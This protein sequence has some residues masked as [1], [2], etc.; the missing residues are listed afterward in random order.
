M[1]N[2]LDNFIV[3]YSDFNNWL[4]EKFP[5]LVLSDNIKFISYILVLILLFDILKF[6]LKFIIEI[7]KIIRSLFLSKRRVF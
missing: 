5:D 3:T 1:L 4:L 2:I 7:I 6:F